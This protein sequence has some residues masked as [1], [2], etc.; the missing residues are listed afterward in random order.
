MNTIQQ[1]WSKAIFF[2]LLFLCIILGGAL[3]KILESFFKPVLLSLFLAF[4]FYP[5]IK[6]ISN[7][8]HLPWTFSIILVYILFFAIFFVLANILMSSIRSIIDSVPQYQA[9]FETIYEKISQ[10]FSENKNSKV[11]S[12]FNMNNDLSLF[13]NIQNQ[14]NIAKAIKRVALEFTN[15]V[16][17]FSKNLFLVTL[18]SIFLL[19]E[20]HFTKTKIKV[21]FSERYRTRVRNVIHN[22]IIE[23]T[24]YISIKFIISLITGTLVTICSC[25]VKLDFPL[26]WGFLAFVLNFIPTFGSIISWAVTTMVAIIQFF[27]NPAPIIFISIAIIALN[28]ILGN[29]IEPRIEGKSLGLSPFVILVSL[30][31]WGWLWGFIGLLMAVPL[32]VIV[33]IVCENIYFLHP[34]AIFIGN[35]PDVKDETHAGE[36]DGSNI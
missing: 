7:K 31:L 9:R 16:Y 22:L 8:L 21:A 34:I 36:K 2:L 29:V 6:K 17:N 19:I 14:L 15:I 28:V 1:R 20:M 33:K 25:I 32:M 12:I 4:I 5:I 27:P 30:S 18:F 35:K 13:E 3:L 11:F 24:N 26:V 10:T 23:I